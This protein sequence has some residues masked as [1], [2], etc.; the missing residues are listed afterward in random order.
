MH[1]IQCNISLIKNLI[2]HLPKESQKKQPFQISYPPWNY[3]T[4]LLKRLRLPQKGR[5]IVLEPS[6]F[7]C[8]LIQLLVSRRI[9]VQQLPYNFHIK[10][11]ESPQG[12][13][14]MTF[15]ST[16]QSTTCHCSGSQLSQ[17]QSLQIAIVSWEKWWVFLS[18]AKDPLISLVVGWHWRGVALWGC[19][20][21]A[22]LDP[23]DCYKSSLT[24]DAE[25]L[26][27]CNK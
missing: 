3:L 18:L 13:R 22:P 24:H 5:R 6:I 12:R 17:A 26:R 23:H 1:E 2:N 4:W 11:S 8:E 25:L 7:R 14:P 15:T 9:I 20:W 10:L 21:G 19:F 16:D 27:E